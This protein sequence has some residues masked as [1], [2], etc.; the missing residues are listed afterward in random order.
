MP[1]PNP[2]PEGKG[3]KEHYA[4][5]IQKEILVISQLRHYLQQHPR[6]SLAELARVLGMEPEALRPMLERLERKGLIQHL[7]ATGS[8]SGCGQCNAAKTDWYQ[9]P[10]EDAA[11]MTCLPFFRWP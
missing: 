7:A 11:E 3:T 1:P 6:A 2:L 8:C 10:T 9:L 5:V 4:T